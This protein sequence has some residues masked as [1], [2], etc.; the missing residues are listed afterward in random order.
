MSHRLARFAARQTV[1]PVV[2]IRHEAQHLQVD[3]LAQPGGY[4]Y[5]PG[6]A[7]HH[8]DA[9]LRQQ[10]SK[11]VGHCHGSLYMTGTHRCRQQ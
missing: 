4:G 8:A 7:V 6:H 5:A 11:L 2:Q 9:G 1:Q 10:A 3:P